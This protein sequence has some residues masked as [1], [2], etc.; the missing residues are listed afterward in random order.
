MK[1][2]TYHREHEVGYRRGL[3]NQ[4]LYIAISQA[5]LKGF[6]T[7]NKEWNGY[8]LD[9]MDRKDRFNKFEELFNTAY[10][11]PKI[12]NENYYNS[13]PFCF[14]SLAN[15][16]FYTAISWTTEE[17]NNETSPHTTIDGST[18]MLE[19]YE[20]IYQLFTGLL[21]EDEKPDYLKPFI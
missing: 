3:S 19:F 12:Q 13:L 15:H 5:V 18:K 20:D 16:I 2:Y 10:P 8:T 6:Q 7:T 4:L 1:T 14:H 9:D 11:T 17:W 21:D